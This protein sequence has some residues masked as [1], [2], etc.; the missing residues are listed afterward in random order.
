MLILALGLFAGSDSKRQTWLGGGGLVGRVWGAKRSYFESERGRE[1]EY[2]QNRMRE[3]G[4][5]KLNFRVAD[6]QTG[7][8]T[9]L[10]ASVA[11]DLH[12]G[13]SVI[14]FCT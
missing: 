10:L 3:L 1:A 6:C 8:S 11:M 12:T 4:S 14:C 7:P 9:G 13:P 5:V 2:Q